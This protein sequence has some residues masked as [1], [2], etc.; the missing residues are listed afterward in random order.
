MTSVLSI[1]ERKLVNDPAHQGLHTGCQRRERWH[2]P[3]RP[4]SGESTIAMVSGKT[5]FVAAVSSVLGALMVLFLWKSGAINIGT[6]YIL[7]IVPVALMVFAFVRSIRQSRSGSKAS[8]RYLTRMA[9]VMAFY[10]LTLFVA[11]NQIEDRGVTGPLAALLALLPGLSFAG[12]I[13]IFG[14]LIVEERDEFFRLLYVRQGLIA[15]GVSFTLAAVWGY[16]ETYRIVDPVVAFWWPTIWCFGIAIGG[17]ANKIKYGTF[18][19]MR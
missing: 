8:Q 13:W 19:E 9:L 5:C 18:G 6:A 17:V 12:V 10:L 1:S 3:V 14:A 15:T 11:E 2:K 7:A 16:L 4:M